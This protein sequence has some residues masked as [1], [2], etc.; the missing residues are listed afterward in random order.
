MNVFA[1]GK[2][3][4]PLDRFGKPTWPPFC[5]KTPNMIVY[6]ILDPEK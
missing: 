2:V 1:K 3:K 4:L 5:F 6:F